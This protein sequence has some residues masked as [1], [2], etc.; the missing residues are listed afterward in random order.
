MSNHPFSLVGKTILITG[1][2][3]GIGR[4]CA[5]VCSQLGVSLI[6]T[7]RNEERLDETLASLPQDAS[8]HRVVPMDI[9]QYDAVASEMEKLEKEGVRIDGM[10]NS[11]GISA[12]LPLRMIRPEKVQALFETNVNAGVNL[13]RWVTRKKMVPGTG[14]SIVFISSVMGITGEAGKTVYSITKGALIAASRSL[15]VELAPKKIRVNC[16]SPGVVESPM[17]GSAVYSRNEKSLEKIK[18]L[19]PL[20]LGQPKD[21]AHA[22]VYLLSDAA[23][24]VTGTNI[25]VDGGYTAR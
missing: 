25:I 24:W 2:S 5:Q 10:I 21:V 15:A 1:A 18:E 17:S 12:T 22:C 9:T 4:A 19:H 14:Q 23:R 16:V 7:G 3:S 13:C 20:G 11:A 8:K 6:L